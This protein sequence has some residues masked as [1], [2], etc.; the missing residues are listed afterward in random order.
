MERFKSKGIRV[1]TKVQEKAIKEVA[2]RLKE[3]PLMVLPE[4][5][6]ECRKCHFKKLQVKLE[7]LKGADEKKLTKYSSGKDLVAA[8]AGTILLADS[9][10]SYFATKEIG[11]STYVYAK[12][13]KA[14][15]EKML[16][17]QNFNDAHIRMLGIVDVASR[18]K[19]YVYS[20]KDRMVC[21]GSNP[22]PPEEFVKFI[23]KKLGLENG[24][25]KHMLRDEG[26]THIRIKWIPAGME[27]KICEECASR[28]TVMEMT[29]YFYSPNIEKEFEVDVEGEFISCNKKC[30]TCFIEDALKQH[31]DDS[32]YLG[33][34]IDDKK[35]IEYWYK[36]VQWNIEKVHEGIFILDNVCY[37]KDAEAVIEK[38]DPSEWEEIALRYI[39]SRLE[40]PLIISNATP[41]KILSK[42]WTEYGE[43]I[44][45]SIAGEKGIKL[46]EGLR[47]HTPSEILEKVYGEVE[48]QKI[49][50]ELPSYK[51]LPPLA[52][53]A[54]RIARAYRVGGYK[55][56]LKD[57]HN[58]KMDVKKK[59]IAYA[60]LLAI[61]KAEGE[62]WK[63]S[64]MERDF[65][66]QLAQY[67][68][69]LLEK[70]GDE[71]GKALQ[72][73]LTMTGST[74]KLER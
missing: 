21:T 59:A 69:L 19:V 72:E 45:K 17:V 7:N 3:N 36:K 54:D 64:D 6:G 70:K 41:N 44:V 56:A 43:D 34:K 28:N 66:H 62:E 73:M 48:K 32:E 12:K 40:R 35:F 27:L 15:D 38:L 16:A 20:L 63:Y 5:Q 29:K 74:K 2:L 71:Y 52:E 11:G 30:D 31:V 8:V 37:G 57:I 42:Y 46:M 18:K 53:F 23:M 60:F 39:L 50:E 24:M 49:L 55:E 47:N 14:K 51:K 33:G 1:A 67:A 9:K 61:G 26:K 10:I 4:C 68:S 65:G 22:T 25:C 58:E 13:G